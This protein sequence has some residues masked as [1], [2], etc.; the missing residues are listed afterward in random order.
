MFILIG[1]KQAQLEPTL[2]ILVWDKN[3]VSN[4]LEALALHK[5][6]QGEQGSDDAADWAK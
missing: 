6:P 4:I 1:C 2:W 3:R 5:I